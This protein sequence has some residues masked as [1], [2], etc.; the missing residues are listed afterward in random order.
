MAVHQCEPQTI[1]MENANLCSLRHSSD[2]CLV[3]LGLLLTEGSKLGSLFSLA[4][5]F[6]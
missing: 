4:F 2:Q 6:S 5:S 3:Q 1:L